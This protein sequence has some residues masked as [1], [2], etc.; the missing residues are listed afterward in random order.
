MR[1]PSL[2]PD[3]GGLYSMYVGLRVL[4]CSNFSRLKPPLGS[5]LRS[6]QDCGFSGEPAGCGR[7]LSIATALA[8][9]SGT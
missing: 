8:E 9:S 7:L 3:G 5:L 1:T 2:D 4:E 6:S